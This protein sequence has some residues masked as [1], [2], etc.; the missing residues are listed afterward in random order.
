MS[1]K[2]DHNDNVITENRKA[3]FNYAI[4]DTVEAGIML[5][6][7]EVKSLRAGQGQLTDSYAIF[8]GFELWLLNAHIPEYSHGTDAN[9]EPLR[10]RKLLLHQYEIHKLKTRSEREG[11]ALIPLKLYWKNG[12]VKVLI[13]VARG[14][15]QHDKRDTIQDR[16][17]ARQQHRLLKERHR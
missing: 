14:K 1:Q 12:K 16:D 15:K 10:S 3:R 4:E 5:Q 9:H 13:G 11:T 2:T 7:T 8:R 17:W 6:G